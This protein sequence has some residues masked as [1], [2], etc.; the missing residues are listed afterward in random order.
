M[1]LSWMRNIIVGSALSI[2][3]MC[4]PRL[5]PIPNEPVPGTNE[6]W[7]AVK[8][9]LYL[10]RPPCEAVIMIEPDRIEVRIDLRTTDQWVSSKLTCLDD[11]L[12]IPS[13][14]LHCLVAELYEATPLGPRVA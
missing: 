8:R 13:C 4:W 5:S 1:S 7:I 12:T 9:R 11:R 10:A 3:P 2:A 6:P 14:G